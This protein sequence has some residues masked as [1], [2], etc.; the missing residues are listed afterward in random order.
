MSASTRRSAFT[1]IEL[2]VVMA[3]IS[4]LVGL[5]LPAVQKVREAAHR[6]SCQ[7]NLRQV[8]IALLSFHDAARRFPPGL[9]ALNDGRQVSVSNFRAPTVPANLRVRSWMTHI[10]PFIEQ[11]NT[12]D[13]LA[14]NPADATNA[15]TYQIPTSDA[16][17]KLVISTYLCAS[18][19][20]GGTAVPLIG[21]PPRTG[22]THYAGVGGVDSSWGGRWPNSDGLLF[23]RSRVAAND[24]KDG[25]SNTLLVGERPPSKNLEFGYWHSLDTIN[26]S[27]GGPD[28]EFD[29]IQYMSNTDIAPFGLN[30][31]SPCPFPATFG[32]GRLDN[33]CDFN[34]FWSHHVGG[35]GFVFA[36][37]S[38][39]FM[40]YGNAGVMNALATRAGREPISNTDY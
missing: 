13:A 7:N 3:I 37:G 19:P 8:G 6:T 39:R 16:A 31:G 25:A 4:T 1:L 35:A 14:L 28:W 10:L 27:K 33:N 12:Y 34:H 21:G 23:W 32:P 9:G 36:D 15:T 22:L 17:G 24:I 20:R 11:Q 5:L 40:L 26:W 2:L 30:S 38:V 29:T 18:E